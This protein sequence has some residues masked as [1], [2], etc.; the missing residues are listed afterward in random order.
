MTTLRPEAISLRTHA[1]PNPL[2]P[3]VT[4]NVFSNSAYGID[5][6]L[7]LLLSAKPFDEKFSTNLVSFH[8]SVM[9]TTSED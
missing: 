9:K 5:N 2:A 4:R 1:S 3:P 8:I 7:T 6:V